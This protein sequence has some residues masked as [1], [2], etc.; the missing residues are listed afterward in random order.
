MKFT[1]IYRLCK[2]RVLEHCDPF[3][4]ARVFNQHS[5]LVTK[6]VTNMF[7]CARLDNGR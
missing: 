4:S 1:I 5:A 7:I 3:K 6:V 2:S